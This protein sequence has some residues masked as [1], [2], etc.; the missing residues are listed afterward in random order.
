MPHQV[1]RVA[2]VADEGELGIVL[3]EVV[4]GGAVHLIG[5]HPGPGAEVDL[6]ENLEHAVAPVVG[7][8]VGVEL[9]P[10]LG[11]Q[12]RD[13]FGDRPVPVEH[14]AADVEGERPNPGRIE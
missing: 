4:E 14:R 9:D 11:G 10:A 2:P 7:E 13:R 6:L 3:H 8:G 12:R 5:V 1:E